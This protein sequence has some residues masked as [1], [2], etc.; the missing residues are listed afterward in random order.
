MRHLVL[1]LFVVHAIPIVIH[2]IEVVLRLLDELLECDY[3]EAM[4]FVVIF[5]VFGIQDLPVGSIRQDL[6]SQ[7]PRRIQKL[8]GF[9]VIG[10]LQPQIERIGRRLEDDVLRLRGFRDLD[11]DL[12]LERLL[13]PRVVRRDAPATLQRPQ[14]RESGWLRIVSAAIRCRGGT[15]AREQS[16]KRDERRRLRCN[17]QPET[18]EGEGC[19]VHGDTDSNRVECSVAIA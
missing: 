11:G 19:E 9:R 18:E 10:L 7:P 13:I 8:E 5:D 17:E 12:D 4:L 14:A 6:A 15:S 16:G 2:D 3:H 1:E